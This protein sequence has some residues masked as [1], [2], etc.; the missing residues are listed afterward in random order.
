MA[1]EKE[2]RWIEPYFHFCYS[3]LRRW[4]NSTHISQMGWKHQ[5]TTYV[6]LVS[7]LNNSQ[8][9]KTQ[10]K[11]K[12]SGGNRCPTWWPNLDRKKPGRVPRCWSGTEE[13][14]GG[15]RWSKIRWW[16]KVEIPNYTVAINGVKMGY[17]LPLEISENIWVT[18]VVNLL[19]E[20]ITPCM[21]AQNSGV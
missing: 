19:I 18:G 5:P 9:F 8:L 21:F 13:S 6:V 4:S 17:N 1:C 11:S 15:D 2:T 20:V 7:I 14:W 12:T 10:K 16:F 3:Y